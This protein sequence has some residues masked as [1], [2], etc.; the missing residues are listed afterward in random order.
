MPQTETFCSC[1]HRSPPQRVLRSPEFN[2]DLACRLVELALS[3][4]ATIDLVI[5]EL[6][7]HRL[8]KLYGPN[9]GEFP[10]DQVDL[11][12][13]AWFDN[14]FSEDQR[15]FINRYKARA[16][17]DR[18]A[19]RLQSRLEEPVALLFLAL[20][21]RECRLRGRCSTAARGPRPQQLEAGAHR[22]G[23]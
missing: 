2:Q 20:A 10:L 19:Y 22:I 7:D 9:G 21:V 16:G 1:D 23:A 14:L 4:D 11:G 15:R 18:F 8:G 3:G 13:V 5:S 17:G 12:A 6:I